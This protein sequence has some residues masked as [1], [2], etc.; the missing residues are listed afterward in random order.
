[1]NDFAICV[2]LCD[3]GYGTSVIERYFA[4]LRAHPDTR[5]APVYVHCQELAESDVGEFFLCNDVKGV[6]YSK[7]R[8]SPFMARYELCHTFNPD[9]EFWCFHDDDL[10]MRPETVYAPML[11][12][13]G[14]SSTGLVMSWYTRMDSRWAKQRA[15][16][17]GQGMVE[18]S[19]CEL[20]GGVIFR[21]AILDVVLQN[22]KDYKYDDVQYSL[23]TYLHGLKNYIYYDSMAMHRYY[24]PTGTTKNWKTWK[25]ELPDPKYLSCAIKKD[26]TTMWPGPGNLTAAA[27]ALHAKRVWTAA[28][29]RGGLL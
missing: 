14:L 1:M 20:G 29:R 26:G 5:D 28:R 18:R 22:P 4:D 11:K 16:S 9:V 19:I 8:K 12:Q 25:H 21:K 23:N 3:R 6:I 24:S 27:K 13:A 7:E 17:F 15:M 2:P 10:L